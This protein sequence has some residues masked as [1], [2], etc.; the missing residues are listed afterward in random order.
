MEIDRTYFVPRVKGKLLKIGEIVRT[1]GRI[2]HGDVPTSLQTEVLADVFA[3]ISTGWWMATEAL[4]HPPG[5]LGLSV[6]AK[7]KT[8][9]EGDVAELLARLK[10]NGVNDG[11]R[12]SRRG[13][14]PDDVRQLVTMAL[15]VG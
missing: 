2:G 10:T 7:V 13:Q 14:E 11:N 8:G 12:T 6:V 15:I 1:C 5:V 9:K 4:N 3:D